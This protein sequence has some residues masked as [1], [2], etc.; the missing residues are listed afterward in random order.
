MRITMIGHC[1]LL[2]E[3]A[4]TRLVTDPFFG[5][6]GHVAYARRRPPAV[7][8]E[9]VGAVD[10]VLLSHGHWD[11]T[12]RK[13]L[14]RLDAS[15]PVLA[16]AG[17]SIVMKLKGA[18]HLVPI[19]RWESVKIGAAVVT[20]VPAVHL[21]IALGYVEQVESLCLYFSGDTYHRPFMAEIARRFR[22]D[23]ALMPVTTF[24]APM[25]MGERGAVAAA[26]DLRPATIIPIH[27]GIEPRS[28]LL[29]TGQSVAG[30]TR[31]L[32]EAGLT[33]EVVQLAEGERWESGGEAPTAGGERATTALAGR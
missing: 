28:P 18:R 30:F 15:I 8:R 20:A 27:L 12:D 17:A 32:R 3:G 11:H 23:V 25:T 19:G 5:T 31:R 21:A 24:R 10:G 29:R 26:R 33:S 2:L 7:T 13:F 6:W 1:T 22:V 9:G 4:G 16:P 14:R